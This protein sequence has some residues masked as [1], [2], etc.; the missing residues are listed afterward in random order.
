MTKDLIAL[1]REGV[2]AVE[3]VFV[4][5]AWQ[6]TTAVWMEPSLLEQLLIFYILHL[7]HLVSVRSIYPR[8]YERQS[9]GPNRTLTVPFT[10]WSGKTV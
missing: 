8:T 1:E 6:I 5:N 2:Y 4:R 9:A 7:K 10:V 3:D